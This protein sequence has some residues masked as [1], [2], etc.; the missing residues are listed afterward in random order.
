MDLEGNHR[1]DWFFRQ[2]VYGTGIP[3]YEFHYSLQD[4]G[5]GKFKL[6]GS[7]KRSGVPANWMDIV[8]IFGEN[9][10]KPARLGLLRVT[11]ATTRWMSPYPRTPAR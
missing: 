3:R 7:L 5:G 9:N 6:S 1:L 8:P 4:A 2:Y 11:Q 10:G